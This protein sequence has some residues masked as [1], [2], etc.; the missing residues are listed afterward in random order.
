MLVLAVI[1]AIPILLFF[2]LVGLAILI[3]SWG[4]I[5]RYFINLG[6]W[7]GDWRNFVPLSVLG[8]LSLIV[9]Y[10]IL[11]IVGVPRIFM[12][13]L[14]I[15]QLLVTLV[16]FV[17][18]LIAW[19]VAL[20]AWFWP[21]WRRLVWGGFVSLWGAM[22]TR[23]GD[24][25]KRRPGPTAEGPTRKQPPQKRSAPASFWDMM[26]GKPSKPAK[27]AASP[28]PSVANVQPSRERAPAKRSWFGTLWAFMLGKPQPKRQQQARPTRVGTSDETLG[29]SGGLATN[30][31][32]ESGVSETA[33]SAVRS[34]R[35]GKPAKRSWFA[36]FWSTMLGRPSKPSQRKMQPK[37]A[38]TG[39]RADGST[40]TTAAADAWT[41]AAS[42]VRTSTSGEKPVKRGFLAGI[43][44]K[45]GE[46][47][48]WIRVRLNLD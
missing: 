41:G 1:A 3:W 32:T 37:E 18:A 16:V 28:Q 12:L 43:G 39:E 46:G 15:L 2:G 24:R 22:P 40:Q 47:I 19:T 31:E 44:K 21:R 25:R 34:V 11:P 38:K 5:G 7:L 13:I 9:V 30:G 14:L 23:S 48:E 8:V 27:P 10:V 29:A 6:A 45:V 20:F 42:S 17:F 4:R 33:S 35:R 26:M 36:S